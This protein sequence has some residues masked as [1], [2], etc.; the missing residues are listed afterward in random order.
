MSGK[1]ASQNP[2]PITE[3]DARLRGRR[4]VVFRYASSSF[5]EL[6]NVLVPMLQEPA[7]NVDDGAVHETA[8]TIFPRLD[9]P[10]ILVKPV[11]GRVRLATLP[12][13]PRLRGWSDTFGV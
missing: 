12:P 8:S 9:T 5:G 11:D 3:L 6:D 10:P 13:L 1:S 4:G 2:H 7:G